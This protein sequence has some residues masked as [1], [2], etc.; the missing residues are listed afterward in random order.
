MPCNHPDHTYTTDSELASY[1]T[2]FVFDT[3]TRYVCVCVL[4]LNQAIAN[5]L[6]RPRY[7]TT[8]ATKTSTREA[9]GGAAA[10]AAVVVVVV[11]WWLGG[12]LLTNLYFTKQGR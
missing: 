8:P 5:A 12:G 3:Y 2:H 11:W 9:F 4:V 7:A 10:A 6:L 1:L